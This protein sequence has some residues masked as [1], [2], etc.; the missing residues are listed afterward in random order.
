MKNRVSKYPGRVL[1]TPDDGTPPFYATLTRADEPTEEG[2]PL[3]K[4]T[5]LTDE[6]AALYDL[7]EDATVNDV[8]GVEHLRYLWKLLGVGTITLEENGT[9]EATISVDDLRKYKEF[10]AVFLTDGGSTY[11][12]IQ[13]LVGQTG[14]T[15]YTVA[16]G[17]YAGDG[18]RYCSTGRVP[19]IAVDGGT[20]IPSIQHVDTSSSQVKGA[21]LFTAPVTR[22]R[23][24][25]PKA[26]SASTTGNKFYI[27]AR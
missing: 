8:L 4:A 2:T 12:S 19:I 7:D 13:L 16:D 22:V 10:F 27:Y 3:N 21:P 5:L 17:V 26:T 9:G 1:V 11:G 20:I 18:A 14:G 15:L 25:F 6:T 24:R 23:V